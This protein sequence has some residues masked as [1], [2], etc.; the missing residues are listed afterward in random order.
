MRRPPEH[1]PVTPFYW[2][3]QDYLIVP[4]GHHIV[5]RYDSEIVL[6]AKPPNDRE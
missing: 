4:P 2:P 6:D 3:T 5:G 1:I